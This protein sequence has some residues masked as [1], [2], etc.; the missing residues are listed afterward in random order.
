MVQILD[1][2]ESYGAPY[3]VME[4]LGGTDLERLLGPG[5]RLPWSTARP[6]LL[7]IVRGLKAAHAAGIVHCDVKPSN[8]FVAEARHGEPASTVKVLDF[9]IAR[10]SPTM[11]DGSSLIGTVTYMAPE[12]TSPAP[13]DAR[14]DVYAMGVL[15]YRVLTGRVPFEHDD[16]HRVLSQHATERPPSLRRWAA[17]VPAAA[18]AVVLQCLAKS[19]QLRLQ[20]MRSLESALE[21]VG[22]T[23]ERRVNPALHVPRIAA[24]GRIAPTEDLGDTIGRPPPEP[25]KT[26]PAPAPV[27]E[28]HDQGIRL[29]M[30]LGV[31]FTL[32]LTGWYLLLTMPPSEDEEPKPLPLRSQSTAEPKPEPPPPGP[33]IPNETPEPEPKVRPEPEPAEP[34]PEIP[35]EPEP[36]P[37]TVTPPPSSPPPAK[38]KLAPK[39]KTKPKKPRHSPAHDARQI[40]RLVADAIRLCHG[41]GRGSVFFVIGP[42]GRVNRIHRRKDNAETKCLAHLVHKTRF[43]RGRPRTETLSFQAKP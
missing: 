24:L 6:I 31:L 17:D 35:P 11:I 27:V 39:P 33:V 23:G 7:Q 37:A 4:L 9:G 30:V 22:A 16:P 34:E 18:E 12:R 2:G 10:A 5:G 40:R 42:D 25:P 41:T 43:S 19:P 3:Y 1:Y 14:A 26:E 15:M 20:D 8:V 28:R 36:P 29:L 32:V 13:P 38:P 21:S